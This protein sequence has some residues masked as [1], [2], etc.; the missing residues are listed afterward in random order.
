M[1]DRMLWPTARFKQVSRRTTPR[2][3]KCH[4]LDGVDAVV[5][6]HSL[7]FQQLQLSIQRRWEVSA[8]RQPHRQRRQGRG[9]GQW[10]RQHH[11]RQKPHVIHYQGQASP[12][13]GV[14]IPALASSSLRLAPKTPGKQAAPPGLEPGN[15]EPKSGVLPITLRGSRA[16]GG[17]ETRSQNREWQ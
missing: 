12:N 9:P 2:S 13:V 16:F 10:C 3:Q 4:D 7:F 8:R 14:V 6:S 11:R 15:T 17:A 1:R 5:A